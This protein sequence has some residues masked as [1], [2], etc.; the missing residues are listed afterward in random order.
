[1]TGGW[2]N[3]FAYEIAKEKAGTLG[4]TGHKLEQTLAELESC[5]DGARRE[6][7]IWYATELVTAIIIQREACGLRNPSFVFEFYGVPREVIARIGVRR[8]I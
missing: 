5:T 6:E 7:L 1:M 8:L 2:V 4:R 3:P